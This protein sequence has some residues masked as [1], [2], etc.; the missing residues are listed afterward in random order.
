[1]AIPQVVHAQT[2][3]SSGEVDISLK[4]NDQHPMLKTSARQM[5]NFR[6]LN[7]KAIT[8]RPG[9]SAQFV[10][11]GRTEE[12][13]MSPGNKF[14]I[15]FQLATPTKNAQISVYTASPNVANANT[16][17]L[18][19]NWVAAA[20]VWLPSALNKI[21]WVVYGNSIYITCDFSFSATNGAQNPI[22][23]LT[24]NG[25]AGNASWSIAQYAEA[26]NTNQKRTF[27]YRI[28]KAGVT[29]LP[30]ASTGNINVTFNDPSILSVTYQQNSVTGGV[31]FGTLN[32]GPGVTA[33][34]DGNLSKASAACPNL[35]VT[36]GAGGSV[37]IDVDI[38]ENY[39]G[40]AQVISSVVLTPPTD[41]GFVLAYVSTGG[42]FFGNV[43]GSVTIN[44]RAKNTAPASP[45]D[46]TLLG[47]V[48][49]NSTDAQNMAPLRISSTDQVSTWNFV[50]IEISANNP[51]FSSDFPNLF[52]SIAQMQ[53]F[54]PSNV[55][56][57]LVGTRMRFV[58]RQIL[59]TGITS[60]LIA[61]ATVEET[62]P[63][64]Q[65]LGFSSD[66]AT[67]YSIGD[68]VEGDVTLA[69][70]VV[71]SINSGANQMT[72]QLLA[73]STTFN[74]A[75][76]GHIVGPGGSLILATSSGVGNPI[77]VT[78]W[79]DEVMNK[80]RGYPQSVFVDQGRLGFCNFPPVPSA[81]GWSALGVFTD[82]YIDGTPDQ[83]IFEIA[84]GKSQALYVI[85]GPENSEFV[86]CDNAVYYI[87]ITVSDPLK[88]GSVAFT[89]LSS[90]GCAQVQ[91]RISQETIIYINA[92]GS[93]VIGILASGAPLRPYYTQDLT[94]NH[95]HLFKTP[96]A[97]A[98]PTA[99]G[100]FPERYA[101]VLNSDGTVA[102]GKYLVKAGFVQDTPGWLPWNGSGSATW[103]SAL[104]AD[105]VFCTTYQQT[106]LPAVTMV[107]LQDATQAM[108]AAF[109]VNTPPT[110]LVA[111]VGQG[112]LW[113]LPG[114]SVSLMDQ[115][116]RA[117][118]VYQIDA[119]GFIIPQF[120]GGENLASLTLVAGQPWVPLI[121]PWIPSVPGGPDQKQ[122]LTR[123][124]IPRIEIYVQNSTGF[125][126]QRLYSGAEGENLP[127]PG[128]PM[129]QN[130][131]PMWMQD[132]DPT[133]PPIQRERGYAF[134]PKG[135][136][137]DPRVQFL[138]DTT[139]TWTINEISTEVTI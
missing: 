49:F 102:V 23:V 4:R 33:A 110:A 64:S 59:I 38:G 55:T 100:Q 24:W 117:M 60:S 125:L 41:V 97:I 48:S 136:A 115:S 78:E 66:P 112:P 105:V 131:I 79:D 82:L 13:L 139:G 83:A 126:F 103:L 40:A 54:A 36:G 96:I 15:N 46:G 68:E 127:V 43:I 52:V 63:G 124:R 3:F 92:G 89:L 22:L 81:I 10:L 90:D 106:G 19:F 74:S 84:P 121:E 98:A 107:E 123:R 45:S 37:S 1:M 99:D 44:L 9:R 133:K 51:G 76:D 61:T 80:L 93:R 128:T 47:T 11:P 88:P 109:L 108:D 32:G 73:G 62:L 50:W 65:V 75:A 104:G 94:E 122:R 130:R 26:L 21:V 119:N 120:A 29:M 135:R 35:T 118:G 56:S 34:F 95:V 70:G 137:F 57:T 67:T 42:G 132:D 5:A 134:R 87:P 85:P 6:I 101:Y 138:K 39:T 28:S 86:M 72:V 113:F 8:N 20:P 17:I 2:D 111:P 16:G 27:F 69:K 14:F 58:D 12:V 30:S 91:P 31:P 114:G 7:S 77:A 71:G 53:P 129:A 25:L 18:Q 116:T